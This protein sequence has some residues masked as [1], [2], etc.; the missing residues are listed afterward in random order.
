MPIRLELWKN[1]G[2]RRQRR[3]NGNAS[4]E[5]ADGCE[6]AFCKFGSPAVV[7][8]KRCSVKLPRVKKARG[9]IF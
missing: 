9:V 4:Y 5:A 2:G 3:S 6:W 7:F 1:R 8:E